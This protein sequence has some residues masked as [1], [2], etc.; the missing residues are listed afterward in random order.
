VL[1]ARDHRANGEQRVCLVRRQQPGCLALDL[2][3]FPEQAPVLVEHAE[4][5]PELILGDPV[6]GNLLDLAGQTGVLTPQVCRRVNRVRVLRQVEDLAGVLEVPAPH[7]G[8]V[9]G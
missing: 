4:G 9:V 8:K 3:E 2:A 6:P 5:G 1:L 7:C